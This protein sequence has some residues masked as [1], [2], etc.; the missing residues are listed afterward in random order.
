MLQPNT[1]LHRAPG[2]DGCFPRPRDAG[3]LRGGVPRASRQGGGMTAEQVFFFCAIAVRLATRAPHAGSWCVGAASTCG[4]VHAAGVPAT[5]LKS[6]GP[7][8]AGWRHAQHRGH[9][10]GQPLPLRHTGGR[11]GRHGARAAAAGRRVRRPRVPVHGRLLRANRQAR[12]HARQV[13]GGTGR[14]LREQRGARGLHVHV[15]VTLARFPEW[16]GRSSGCQP[17][18]AGCA[19]RATRHP[20]T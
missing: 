6:N 5:H 4:E 3:Q 8:Q 19:H 11:R 18:G 15:W 9:R 1:R 2:G 16:G 7:S 10:R 13:H 17:L 14:A 20:R 12:L